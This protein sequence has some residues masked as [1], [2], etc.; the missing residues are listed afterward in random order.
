MKNCYAYLATNEKLDRSNEN[1]FPVSCIVLSKIND[2][3]PGFALPFGR[4][5][6]FLTSSLPRFQFVRFLMV[7]CTA[8]KHQLIFFGEQ[9]YR[10]QEQLTRRKPIRSDQRD[11]N[12]RA[13]FFRN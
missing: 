4:R 2:R 12:L 5:V 3:N 7:L 10:S 6:P 13:S 1:L 8:G 9:P 11:L